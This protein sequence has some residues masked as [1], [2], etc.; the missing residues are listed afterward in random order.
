MGL[1]TRQHCSEDTLVALL[2]GELPEPARDEA[3]QH[4]AI[5]LRCSDLLARVDQSLRAL[6]AEVATDPAVAQEAPRYTVRPAVRA[7][8]AGML[9]GSVGAL[10]VAGLLVRRH[11]RRTMPR[12][13]T[14]A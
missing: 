7:A 4:L 12:G 1:T 11:Q 6:A 2:D 10:V 14:A 9:A 3:E 8:G 5:C 13:A